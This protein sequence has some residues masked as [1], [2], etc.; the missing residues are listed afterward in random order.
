MVWTNYAQFLVRILLTLLNLQ[1]VLSLLLE[2]IKI[3]EIFYSTSSLVD[4]V[5][6]RIRLLSDFRHLTDLFVTVDLSI[7]IRFIFNL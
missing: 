7:E 5:S 4:D 1:F 3:Y 2:L 6:L